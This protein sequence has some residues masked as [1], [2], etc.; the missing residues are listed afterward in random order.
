M[1]AHPGFWSACAMCAVCAVLGA[2][3]A[4][5]PAPAFAQTAPPPASA[6][7]LAADDSPAGFFDQPVATGRLQDARGG[8]QTVQNDMTLSGATTGNTA[9]NLS[10]G[11]NTIGAGA[12]S[13]MSGLPVVIQNSG[14]NVLIQNATLVHLELN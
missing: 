8:S 7:A 3:A 13:S 1:T 2:G 11:A 9:I 5:L 14:A 10:T 12:F 6:P 4:A